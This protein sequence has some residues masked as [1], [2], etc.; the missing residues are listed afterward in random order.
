MILASSVL[1]SVDRGYFQACLTGCGTASLIASLTALRRIS[2]GGSRQP[3]GRY[4]LVNAGITERGM[5]FSLRKLVRGAVK[6]GKKV[7]PQLLRVTPVGALAIRAQ[8]A[9][10]SLGVNFRAAK[11]KQ[12]PVSVQAAIARPMVGMASSRPTAR[13]SISLRPARIDASGRSFQTP[14]D[15]RRSGKRGLTRAQQTGLTG[16]EA[17]GSRRKAKVRTGKARTPPKGGLDLKA[18][19]ALWRSQGKPGSW[20]GFIKANPLRK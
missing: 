15:M 10:K 17:S 13:R 3:P 8:Q 20:Q 2:S 11:K 9:A 1:R 16:F 14:E 6:I 12:M 7:A 18:I 5:G 19:A 4:S